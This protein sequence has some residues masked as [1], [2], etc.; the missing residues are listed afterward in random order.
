MHSAC[1]ALEREAYPLTFSFAA[2]GWLQ[3]YLF[4][5][6]KAI[7]DCGLDTSDVRFAGS[8]AGSLASAALCAKV[9]FDELQEYAVECSRVCRSSIPNAFRI[10]EYVAEGI[11]RFAVNVFN[12]KPAVRHAMN[13]QLEVYMSVLPWCR[14]KVV[15]TFEHVDD[16][17][18]ALLASCCITPL[19]GMPFQLR[20]TGEWVV[21]GG[22]TAF[23]PRKGQPNVITISPLYF[24]SADI[25]PSVFV[26]AWWGLYPPD[27]RRYRALYDLGFNDALLFL[28]RTNRVDKS[29]ITK[30]RPKPVEEPR[31][32]SAVALDVAAGVFFIF[33]MRPWALVLIYLEM[34]IVTCA[35]LLIATLHDLLPQSLVKRADE[36]LRTR[37]DA[38]IDTWHSLR[39][40]ISLR[41]LAHVLIGRRVPVNSSR[42]EKFSRLYRVFR[43]FL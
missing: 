32:W 34:I 5:I 17:E 13:E 20:A 33:V 11:R 1:E 28:I 41:V 16:L 43:P 26:P 8:S 9:D 29:F 40:L 6:S 36:A 12:E 35:C 21:D 25:K 19:A 14:A 15:D 4:G 2:A 42:L 7:Q 22:L 38:W 30:L 18:E 31:G 10:R 37:R 3:S 27:E 24:T 23:Q 39:N